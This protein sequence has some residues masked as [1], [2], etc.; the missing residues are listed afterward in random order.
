MPGESSPSESD[1]ADIP[2]VGALG[3]C[4]CVQVWLESHAVSCVRLLSLCSRMVGASLFGGEVIF[5]V[6]LVST[7]GGGSVWALSDTY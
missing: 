4:V 7:F 5:A 3:E 2:E 1:I 6:L